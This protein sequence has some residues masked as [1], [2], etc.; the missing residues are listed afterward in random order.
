MIRSRPPLRFLM[1]AQNNS[2]NTNDSQ[3]SS[4]KAKPESGPVPNSEHRHG[5]GS[6]AKAI[7]YAFIAN[8]CIAIA[9]LIAAIYTS[10]GSMMAE[11]I[12][13]FADSGNQV[14]LFIGLKGAEKP[15]D[16]DHPMGYGKLSYFWSFIVA[17]MLF[18]VGGIYSVYEGWHKLSSTAELSHVWVALLVL[19]GAILIE[20]WSLA[21]AVREANLMRGKRS[22]GLWLKNTRNAEIVVVLGEDFAA[23]VGL[24]LAFG[25]LTAAYLTGNPVYDAYGSIC[26]GVVLI[27]V[28]MFVAFRIQSLLIG[29]SA[30]PEL[31][32]LIKELIAADENIEHLFNAITMQFG[33]KVMLAAKIKMDDNIS[34]AEA[35][36]HINALER[37]IKAAFPEVGWCFIE[38]DDTDE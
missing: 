37:D 5:G 19:G 23:I 9:K 3:T 21:G 25:F 2:K 34:L 35:V 18:S 1:M 28:A 36:N 13:S 12:H 26:I 27:A 11:S 38:P 10:S 29:K 17:L 22:F 32:E 20:G 14:L 6:P 31:Q 16:K 33:P 8:S 30:E 4:P 7:L 15:A 24:V